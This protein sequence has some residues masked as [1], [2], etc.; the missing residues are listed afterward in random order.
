MAKGDSVKQL[1]EDLQ[2]ILQD[3]GDTNPPVLYAHDATDKDGISILLVDPSKIPLVSGL[4]E[5]GIPFAFELTKFDVM[6]A[7]ALAF[8]VT[9]ERRY[10]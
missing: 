7:R 10:S 8:G 2:K 6:K 4:E 1:E 3:Q 5:M 9:L